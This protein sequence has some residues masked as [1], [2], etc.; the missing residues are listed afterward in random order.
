MKNLIIFASGTGTNAREI[1][2]HFH[3]SSS[4]R[5]KLIVCNNA[6]AGVLEIAQQANIPVLLINRPL[7]YD[8]SEISNILS[9]FHPDLIVL[10]GFLWKIPLHMIEAFPEKIINIH[11]ALLPRYGGRG[12]YG[13]RVHQ[14]VIENGDKES[15]ITIHWVNENYDE[16]KIILQKSCPVSKDDTAESLAQKVHQL[17]HR[18][19]ASIIENLLTDEK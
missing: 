14:A 10:A 19:Y 1:I 18:W 12:M 6:R 4:V 5:V 16:G 7:L 8:T 17:E 3:T 15:G 2:R 13:A 11:P 9:S